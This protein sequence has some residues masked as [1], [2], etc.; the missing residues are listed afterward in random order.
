MA[1]E[2]TEEQKQVFKDAAARRRAAGIKLGRFTILADKN[3]IV[4]LNDFL[5][6]WIRHLGKQG[7]I[8]FLI[9]CMR[10]GEEALQRAME[11]R[12]KKRTK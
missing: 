3:Q 9:V 6:G 1:H 10:R 4:S 8:D 5:D 7:A 11:E 12:K 2:F